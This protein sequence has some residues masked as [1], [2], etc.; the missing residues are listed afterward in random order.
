MT[1]SP[2]LD[3][4]QDRL[5]SLL[6][7]ARATGAHVES[8]DFER[9][10]IAKRP[11]FLLGAGSALARPFVEHALAHLPV[12]ALVDNARAG[13]SAGGRPVIG[14]SELPAMLVPDAVG[15]LCCNSD[16]AVDHFLSV[17]PSQLPLFSLLQ[18]ARRARVP[19]FTDGFS[20]PELVERSFETCWGRM[21]DEAGRRTLLH[22]LLYRL[23]MEYRWLHDIRHP[24]DAMYF[25]NQPMDIG[26][27]EVFLD[28]GGFDGDTVAAFLRRTGRQYRAIHIAEPEHRNVSAI[29][30]KF[31]DLPG[32]FVHQRALW[33]HSTVLRFSG[34][35][36]GGCLTAH[37]DIEVEATAIDDLNVSPTFVKM[38]IEGAEGPALR[39]AAQTIREG[40][41]K[42]AISAYHRP[43]DLFALMNEILSLRDDYR[44]S[45]RHYSPFIRDTVIYAW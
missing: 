13:N 15:V 24:Y 29:T 27:D 6:G 36:E 26:S 32:I 10:D 45:L 28:G 34:E 19:Y 22:L 4:L 2:S 16:G 30:R 33:S 40:R 37:G 5:Q 8:E 12:V 44:F 1:T 25:W 41:P 3:G 23:T 42:L 20:S 7:R 14:T 31:A 17:W 21:A 18:A 11:L 38:D 35:G 39:G 9:V 43:D